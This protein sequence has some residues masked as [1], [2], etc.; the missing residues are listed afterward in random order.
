M[1]CK[2]TGHSK[3]LCIIQLK[4]TAAN[5]TSENNTLT[6][7]KTKLNT[8]MIVNGVELF[9][10]G[11]TSV[12]CPYTMAIKA[13]KT[14]ATPDNTIIFESF[15]IPEADNTFINCGITKDK[16]INPKPTFAAVF[17]V[18]CLL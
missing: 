15:V 3:T 4:S 17:L 9:S 7:P 2:F 18:N 6:Y 8:A 10:L 11:F 13:A 12:K 1:A 16:T 5:I 14:D